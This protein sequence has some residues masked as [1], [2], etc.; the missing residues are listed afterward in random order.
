[1]GLVKPKIQTSVHYCE[2]TKKGLIKHYHDQYNLAQAPEV[3]G[4]EQ[5]NAFPT[6]DANDNPLS[7]EYGYCLYKDS[8]SITIQEMPERA[9]TGQLPRSIQVI[10]ENDLVE[11]VKPGDRIQVNGVFKAM[12]NQGTGTSGHFRT[13]IVATG[14]NSLLA[15][16]EKPIMSEQDLKNIKGLSREKKVFDIL[17]QSI[18]PSIHGSVHVKKGIL[19]QLMGGAEK[20]LEN[21][22]HL[23]GDINIMMV[24]D[25]STAK[26]QLLRHVM[27]IAPLAINT[28]GRG[29]SGVGLTA[30]VSVDKETGEKH[31]E[32]GAM[33][34]ADR[35]IVCIDEFD[36]MVDVDRVAIH[37]VMEQQ[38]VTIA[39]AGIHTSLNARCS[40]IAAANPI[41]GEYA[42]DVS[43]GKNIGLPDSLLSRFDLLF[44]M[45]DEKDPDNDRK[46]ANRVIQNH[47][48]QAEG[49]ED[50][51]FFH[52]D[53]LIEPELKLSREQ[54]RTSEMYEK[55]NP[56][57]GSKLNVVTRPFLK[58][59]ISY[60]KSQKAPELSN[61]ACEYVAQAYSLLRFK[62]DHYDKN[63]V[64][65][66][67][68]VRTLETLIRLAT[69]HA[70]MR[71]SKTVDYSDVEIALGLVGQSIFNEESSIKEESEEEGEDAEF[72][73][74]PK[75][76][77]AKKQAD[78]PAKKK[79]EVV[80]AKR[81]RARKSYKEPASDG[82]DEDD[83][84]FGDEGLEDEGPKRPGKRRRID[85]DA[86]LD[87][88]LNADVVEHGP[89]DMQ[90]KREL[91]KLIRENADDLQKIGFESLESLLQRVLKDPKNK[92]NAD[93]KKV[94]KGSSFVDTIKALEN[95][96]LVQYLKREKQVILI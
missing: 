52:D 44:V 37:E 85:R 27:D 33:V 84:D 94:S 19:L 4:S 91:Y 65:M 70:K 89:V 25:P 66:P 54:E 47:L 13:V 71:L 2:K 15:E 61:E 95:D 77:S 93:L 14:V 29:S 92:G 88:V 75:K 41:Y 72:K 9:P 55:H 38:T 31:L 36:K 56:I 57:P 86:Q 63:K 68:T 30:A 18:A 79:Q 64:S 17:G 24:G 50:T 90:M 43:V 46:I 81:E 73:P 74:K 7:A 48:W 60:A 78:S 80:P 49:D 26:S 35:G 23:R 16:K 1:M 76:V 11:K 8:Q 34:L 87:S 62:A 82:E 3:E 39:K 22:T 51:T 20:N 58:K 32:A 53:F 42:R 96:G 69:A 67:I 12:P 6:K 59:Y 10:L 45:L 28:T 83:L 5:N 40:V 21:G